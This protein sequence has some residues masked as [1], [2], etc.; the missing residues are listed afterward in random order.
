MHLKN[1]YSLL[2]VLLTLTSCRHKTAVELIAQKW[3]CVSVNVTALENQSNEEKDRFV[4][5]M[6][7]SNFKES[8]IQFFADKTYEQS[9]IAYDYK[10]QGAYKLIND[11][12]YM[13][14]KHIDVRK[15]E[16][17]EK[18]EIMMLTEDTLKLKAKENY[19][20]VFAKKD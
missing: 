20:L 15:E 18:F 5:E 3:Q 7:K 6:L 2:I 1:L 11:G 8:S 17:E 19:V 12:K 14:C 10:V 4:L 16:K 9:I 13:I